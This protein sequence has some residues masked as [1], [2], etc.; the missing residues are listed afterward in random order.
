MGSSRQGGVALPL[1]F[2]ANRRAPGRS[3]RAGRGRR[4]RSRRYR[5]LFRLRNSLDFARL[6]P[7]DL[8]L[9]A[10]PSDPVWLQATLFW[11]HVAIYV[12]GDDSRA[13]VDAVNLP[14]R[15]A[16]RRGDRTL[17]WQRV[18]FTSRRAFESYVD[19]L[20]LR[21]L[22]P[23]DA[24]RAAAEFAR[25][26]V[27]KPF[28]RRP[29]A[30]ILKGWPGGPGEPPSE[31]TC[32]SLVWEAYRRQGLDLSPRGLGRLFFPWPSRL[33]H[34]RRLRH[35]GRGTRLRPISPAAGRLGYF[36]ARAWFKWGLRS[37]ILWRGEPDNRG[38]AECAR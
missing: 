32:S 2:S 30:G 5:R 21:P 11:S 16:A 31:Y 29:A 19:L 6:E 33:D 28:C 18:R 24:R 13:F 37:D 38:G 20:V 35:V 17:L 1:G 14:V 7:G 23:A 34:D 8:I 3:R 4:A 9:V 22:L 10:N 27:G 12:G 15:G 25:S 26:Q 36:L